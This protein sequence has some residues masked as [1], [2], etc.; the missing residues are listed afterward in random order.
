M[1]FV[2]YTDGASRGNPGESGIG[3]VLRT[4]DGEPVAELCGYLGHS[5]NNRAE[6]AALLACVHLAL[7]HGC[8]RLTVFS[9]SEL[10]V[11]QVQG[12]YKIKDPEL[13]RRA[14]EIRSLVRTRRVEMDLQ[15]V[16]RSQNAEADR[17][18]NRA[19]DDRAPVLSEASTQGWLFQTEG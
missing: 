4:P 17:L 19:I 8:S 15:H 1:H 2:A 12:R 9:D 18:A 16:E 11:R 6:Y 13:R 10:M 7:R 14:D 5:T 3:V